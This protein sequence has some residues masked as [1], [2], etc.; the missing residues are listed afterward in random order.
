MTPG[1]AVH[2]RR[3]VGFGVRAGAAPGRVKHIDGDRVTVE[4]PVRATDG[5]A[6]QKCRVSELKVA[7]EIDAARIAAMF[8]LVEEAR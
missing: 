3:V 6:V 1:T 8:R 7:K 4:L 2:I 5:L